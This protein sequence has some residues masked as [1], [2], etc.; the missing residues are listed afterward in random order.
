MN[1]IEFCKLFEKSDFYK[2]YSDNH[3][4]YTDCIMKYVFGDDSIKRVSKLRKKEIG[5]NSY[6]TMHKW[7]VKVMKDFYSLFLNNNDVDLETIKKMLGFKRNEPGIYLDP[8]KYFSYKD[9][10]EKF[11][12]INFS[13][14][15]LISIDRIFKRLNKF[16]D[17]FIKEYDESRKELVFFF[18]QE[19]G[20]INICRKSSFNDRIEYTL[21]DIKNYI[22][23]RPSKMFNCYSKGKTKEWLDIIKKQGGFKYLVELYKINDV[24]VKKIE[25]EYKIFD[26]DVNDGKTFIEKIPECSYFDKE[27]ANQKYYEN[28]KSLLKKYSEKLTI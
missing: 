27:W 13:G 28:I 14:D 1:N 18:P 11:K 9:I 17:E 10:E 16:D 22:E 6:E 15:S 3:P 21:F 20:G 25:G 5:I 7:N 12:G 19:N 8:D 2:K 24:F 4:Y 26:I 23:N